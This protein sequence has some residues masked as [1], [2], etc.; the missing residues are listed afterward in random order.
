MR[1]F[2]LLVVF[3][4]WGCSESGNI[5]YSDD[6]LGDSLENL[7]D[8]EIKGNLLFPRVFFDVKKVKAFE[9]DT[10][11]NYA[12]EFEVNDYYI[13]YDI[14]ERNYSS[15]YV[16]FVV[17]G[18]W[19]QFDSVGVEVEFESIVDVG[20]S[21]DQV[22]LR[23]LSHL[24][25]PRVKRLLEDGYPFDVAKKKALSEILSVYSNPDEEKYIIDASEKFKPSNDLV[26]YFPYVL[27]MCGESDS[28]FVENIKHFREDFSKGS[29]LDFRGRMKAT[30]CITQNWSLLSSQMSNW[31]DGDISYHM[32]YMRRVQEKSYG[33]PANSRSGETFAVKDSLS[34][35]YQDSLVCLEFGKKGNLQK[36]YR[37]LTELEKNIG[38]CA[39]DSSKEKDTTVVEFEGDTYTCFHRLQESV[40][41]SDDDSWWKKPKSKG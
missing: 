13:A 1:Y 27:L 15:R 24:E 2:C 30:D 35:F 6:C 37:P 41:K 36:I 11:W 31:W 29:W 10:N 40:P 19:S 18:N 4:L 16:Q 3:V 22:N 38:V 23:L 5:I 12:K 7:N 21:A 17:V 8:K 9:L 28:G 14:N 25:I 39:Y 26:E 34:V 33:L 32:E 20:M